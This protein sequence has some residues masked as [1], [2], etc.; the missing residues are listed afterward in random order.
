LHDRLVD[1][2]A[3]GVA[4]QD[5]VTAVVVAWHG[6]VTRILAAVGGIFLVFA[7]TIGNFVNDGPLCR[8][9]TRQR[10]AAEQGKD[11]TKYF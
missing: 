9:A 11:Q 7:A 4:R 10:Q 1:E 6:F 5:L 3:E 8:R 2:F